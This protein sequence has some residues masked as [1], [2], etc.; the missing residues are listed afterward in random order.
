MPDPWCLMLLQ[1]LGAAIPPLPAASA[2]V[3]VVVH[4]SV[5]GEA[6]PIAEAWDRCHVTTPIPVG[7][8]WG[9]FEP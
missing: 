5:D 6:D 3:H 1:L 2:L 8:D 9:M 7:I 4:V